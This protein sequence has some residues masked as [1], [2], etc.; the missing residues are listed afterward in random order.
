M[1]KKKDIILILSLMLIVATVFILYTL[2]QKPSGNI[3]R[4]YNENFIV[5]EVDFSTNEVKKFQQPG[6]PDYP[7]DIS[8]VVDE[9]ADLAF[10]IMGSYL[11]DGNRT[12]VVI[13]IDFDTKS[14]RIERDSTPKQIGV[15]RSWYNGK[16]LPVI[17]LP[18]QVFIVFENKIDDDLDGVL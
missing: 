3:A 12:E 14:L 5:L 4:V 1:M 17:S 8:F 2:N 9:G 6:F 7:K 16:G 15:H 18:N 11:I 13:E 10:V